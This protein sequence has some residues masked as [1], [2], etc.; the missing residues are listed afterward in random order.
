MTETLD[1]TDMIIPPRADAGPLVSPA[2]AAPAAPSIE[3]ILMLAVERGTDPANLERLVALH[4]R[5]A[6]Q[7]AEQAFVAAM[8]AFSEQCPAVMKT[9]EAFDKNGKQLYRYATLEEVTKVVDPVLRKNGL[10]YSWDTDLLND[11]TVVTCTVRHVA[12]HK[13]SSKFT[14]KGTGTQIMSA[15]QIAASATTFG[16]R[17]SLL[18]ALGITADLDT[19]DRRPVPQPQPEADA[20]APKVGTRAER[21][22]RQPA[23]PDDGTPRV[24]AKMLNGLVEEWKRKELGGTTR[25]VRGVGAAGPGDREADGHG[26]RLDR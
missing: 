19:D 13:Q 26:W 10:T 21:A 16:R 8:L 14:C 4:E 15:A 7:R 11:L 12:G 6:A 18:C 25:A 5:V 20:A 1:K 3:S 24:S 17:Y 2:P 23:A 22:A 9:G